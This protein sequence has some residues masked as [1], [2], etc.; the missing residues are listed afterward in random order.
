MASR[1]RGF[2]KYAF[3]GVVGIVARQ[4]AASLLDVEDLTLPR[5]RFGRS[6]QDLSGIGHLKTSTVDRNSN[7]VHC[8]SQERE[9][10]NYK[11]V[12]Y[13]VERG[14][15]RRFCQELKFK[16]S[17]QEDSFGKSSGWL[18]VI[19]RHI[20]LVHPT[21]INDKRASFIGRQRRRLE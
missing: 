18:L 17:D 21:R 2:A 13:R 6:V 14:R 16:T 8:S 1:H 15:C 7:G 11:K 9:I 4:E 5:H 3:A 12:V 10:A 20:N 19:D